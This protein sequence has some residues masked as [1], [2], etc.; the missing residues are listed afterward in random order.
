MSSPVSASMTTKLMPFETHSI[1]S[2]TL[3]VIQPGAGIS[4]DEFGHE[5]MYAVPSCSTSPDKRDWKPVDATERWLS[6]HITD[7][8]LRENERDGEAGPI[9]EA[10]ACH[11]APHPPLRCASAGGAM[12]RRL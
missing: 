11:I 4:F 5:H 9:D 7:S 2:A 12:W 8:R 3:S 10:S 6:W 1:K